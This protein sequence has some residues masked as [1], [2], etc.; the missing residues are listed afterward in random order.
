MNKALKTLTTVIISSGLI[1]G[2]IKTFQHKLNI[3]REK[4]ISTLEKLADHY[5]I[6]NKDSRIINNDTIKSIINQD[7]KNTQEF[8]RD[9]IIMENSLSKIN[10]TL[11]SFSRNILRS[12]IKSNNFENIIEEYNNN[13]KRIKSINQNMN[14]NADLDL[15]IS[16]DSDE[17]ISTVKKYKNIMEY[18]RDIS[19]INSTQLK[20]VVKLAEYR[21]NDPEAIAITRLVNE[22]IDYRKQTTHKS[23][24]FI[25]VL[26]AGIKL[27]TNSYHKISNDFL[28]STKSLDI[29]TNKIQNIS[30]KYNNEENISTNKEVTQKNQDIEVLSKAL[31]NKIIYSNR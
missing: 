9:Y 10:P 22:I 18:I 14:N 31:G 4:R 13:T 1:Y 20:T 16:Y 24:Y 12:N 21:N 6:I 23:E 30:D 25:S 7:L 15:L 17:V 28:F 29:N 2:G 27:K 5:Q 3:E 8:L 11:D 19:S 26:D